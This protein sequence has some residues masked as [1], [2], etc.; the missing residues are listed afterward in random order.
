MIRQPSKAANSISY[1]MNL[2]L[3][4]SSVSPGGVIVYVASRQDHYILVT[5]NE[6]SVVMETSIVTGRQPTSLTKL[7]R[8]NDGASHKVSVSHNI[9]ITFHKLTLK[10]T[11]LSS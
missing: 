9:S 7:V 8:I 6:Y 10:H 2:Q 3:N 4:V 1:R 11:R 5:F